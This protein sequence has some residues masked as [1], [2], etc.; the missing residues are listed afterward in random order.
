[1]QRVERSQRQRDSIGG[2]L[3]LAGVDADER[4]AALAFVPHRGN[5]RA[6]AALDHGQPGA[7]QAAQPG[8]IPRELLARAVGYPVR[9]AEH[10]YV[11]PGQRAAM[12]AFRQWGGGAECFWVDV[13]FKVFQLPDG[14][15]ARP[16]ALQVMNRAVAFNNSLGRKAGLLELA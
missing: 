15:A 10:Q 12:R 8:A 16:R 11:W 7:A 6:R 3:G 14:I 1:M 9:V 4:A 5:G 2:S 13:Q